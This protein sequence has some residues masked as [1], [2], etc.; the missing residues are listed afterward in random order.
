MLENKW[1]K[2]RQDKKESLKMTQMYERQGWHFTLMNYA[3]VVM[4]RMKV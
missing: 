2:C 4:I 3:D 1:R